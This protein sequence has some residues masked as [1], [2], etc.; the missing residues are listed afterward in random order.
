MRELTIIVIPRVKAYWRDLAYCMEYS[1]VEVDGFDRDGRN[2]H[3]CCEKLFKNWLE[4]GHG[5][6]PKTYQTLL[7]YIKDVDYLNSA[8]EEINAELTKG[9]EK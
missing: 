5:P 1:I 8:S 9:K 2:L 4:T 7:K 3:E 6:T